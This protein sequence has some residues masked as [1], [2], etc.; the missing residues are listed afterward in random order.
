MDIEM[1][2][3]SLFRSSLI[4]NGLKGFRV[5]QKNLECFRV[6]LLQHFFG[7]KWLFNSFYNYICVKFFQMDNTQPV[8]KYWIAFVISVIVQIVF[9]IWF[10]QY[11]WLILPWWLTFF[12]KGMRLIQLNAK[13]EKQEFRLFILLLHFFSKP[14]SFQFQWSHFPLVCGVFF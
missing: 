8:G 11:F 13:T 6:V 2:Q 12:C 10:R 14:S 7:K 5:V 1:G 4:Q 3:N 9:L